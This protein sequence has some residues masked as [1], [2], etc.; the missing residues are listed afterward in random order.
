VRH[1]ATLAGPS[2]SLLKY[3]TVSRSWGLR[4]NEAVLA[5]DRNDTNHLL[6][7][8][9]LSITNDALLSCRFTLSKTGI[10]LVRQRLGGTSFVNPAA[11][12]CYPLIRPRSRFVHR[13]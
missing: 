2:R 8:K 5:V 9:T 13:H 3:N 7:D 12:K 1:A 4:L 6:V 11:K 10:L